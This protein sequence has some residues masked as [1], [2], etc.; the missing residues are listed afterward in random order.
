MQNEF[1]HIFQSI[2][3][4]RVGVIG[5]F[6]VDVYYPLE[7]DSGELSLETG[8]EVHRAGQC[9]TY[10]GA[11]GNVVKNLAALGVQQIKVFGLMAEDMWGRE[12][13]HLLGEIGAD[14]SGMLIQSQNWHSCAYVKPMMGREEDHRID[15]GSYNAPAHDRQQSVLQKLEEA[16]PQ[17]DL[18]IINQQFVRPLLDKKAVQ[19]LNTLANCFPH[20]RFVADMRNIAAELRGITLKANVQEGA[21][22]LEIQDFDA[23]DDEQC[24]QISRQLNKLLQAPVLL[25]RGENGMLYFDGQEHFA[26]PGIWHDT[27]IDPVGAGDTALS[28]FGSALAARAEVNHS[29]K[30]A[31]LAA[32]VTVRK[33]YQTG[34]ASPGEMAALQQDCTY[35][36]HNYLAAYPAKARFYN[37]SRLEVVENFKRETPLRF[38]MMDHD[39]TISVLREGWEDLMLDLMLR[40]I[41]GDSLTRLSEADKQVLTSKVNQLIS[42]TTGAPTIVQMEGLVEM[43]KREGYVEEEA[44]RTAEDYK[45]L[46]LEDLHRH[47]EK[48]IERFRKGEL[49]I[50]DVTVKGVIGFI[51]RMKEKGLKL[52]LASGTDEEYVVR[53]AE[54]LGYA[55][56]FQGGIYGARPDGG[57]AKRKVLLQLTLQEGVKAREII[58]IGDGPSEIREG[59][60]VGALCVGV[61]SDE[62]RRYGLNLYKRERLI[63]AGSHIIIEDFSQLDQLEQLLLSPDTKPDHV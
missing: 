9:R 44:V 35:V 22:M 45:A 57:S 60:K 25:T 62:L 5:D 37:E 3:R 19:Q 34:S 58:V 40:C 63:R 16:L 55:D 15:F 46:Y 36:Y 1:Q 23:R 24:N 52:Y 12:L 30:L 10:P 14:T 53:E 38:V 26:V 28:A 27:E 8:K 20:C 47:V 51:H 49:Q 31:N 21:R 39:G 29:L 48:R 4:L 6:A 50:D 32:S 59:R 42:Q 11:A 13:L 54:A 56:N 43:V 41:A 18:L 2:S 33:L 7:K 17:L 61:A